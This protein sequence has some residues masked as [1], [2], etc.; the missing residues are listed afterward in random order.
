MSA[1]VANAPSA[2]TVSPDTLVLRDIHLPPAP[3]WWPPAPGWWAVAG[4][5]LLLL[6]A[7]ALLW[8]RRGQ[9]SGREARI[10]REIDRLALIDDDVKLA[11]ALHQWLRRAAR[12]YAPEA[13][14]Q[15]G[16]AWQRTLA[17]VPVDEATLSQLQTLEPRMY[18]PSA[19]FDRDVVLAAVRRWTRLAVRQR[20]LRPTMASEAVA[21]A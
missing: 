3:P 7:A 12:V 16:E 9:R 4:L 17:Q 15:R 10:L 14:R 18:L 5:L 21:D 11:T 8:R 6:I 1:P 19:P 2:N 13:T 20:A